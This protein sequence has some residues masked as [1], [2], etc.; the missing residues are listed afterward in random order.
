[1]SVESIL[2]ALIER[3]GGF[4]DHSEDRG[5]AT[6]FGITRRT[7]SEWRGGAVTA[8]DVAA[9]SL[10][11]AKRIYRDRYLTRPGFLAIADPLLLELVVDSAVNHGVD[12]TIR[13]L[14]EIVKVKPDGILGPITKSALSQ[15]SVHELKKKLLAARVRFYGRII[16]LNPSQS[17][18]AEGWAN[19][20]ADLIERSL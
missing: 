4:V 9:L 13:M 18:F 10:D 11:E 2:D 20:A 6:K 15:L 17:V 8:A 16:R 19:R 3:E 5:G 12:R 7:L 1:M 14:Q